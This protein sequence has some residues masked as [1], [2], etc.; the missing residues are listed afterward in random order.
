MYRNFEA[1][2]ARHSAGSDVT[3]PCLGCSN[4]CHSGLLCPRH[5]LGYSETNN[6]VV[7]PVFMNEYCVNLSS[8]DWS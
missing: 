1:A 5:L 7:I 8:I 4:A 2:A 3:A 6:T